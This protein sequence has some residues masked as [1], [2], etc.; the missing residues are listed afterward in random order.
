MKTFIFSIDFIDDYTGQFRNMV[1]E[2]RA[3]DYQS[4][5]RYKQLS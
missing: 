3:K 1:K 4:A 5:K 2:Y